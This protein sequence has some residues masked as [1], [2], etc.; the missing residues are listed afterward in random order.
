MYGISWINEL[1]QSKK[2]FLQQN[3]KEKFKNIIFK[4]QLRVSC[5]FLTDNPVLS[6]IKIGNGGYYEYCVGSSCET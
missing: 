2:M 4:R 1:K 5:L 6:T 3:S